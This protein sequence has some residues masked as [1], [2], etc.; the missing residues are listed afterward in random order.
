MPNPFQNYSSNKLLELL[1]YFSKESKIVQGE[2]L[3]KVLNKIDNI[4]AELLER[5]NNVEFK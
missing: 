4:N 1:E 5:Q 3:T 2:I